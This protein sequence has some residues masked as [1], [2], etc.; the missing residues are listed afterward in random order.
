MRVL[1]DNKPSA[2]IQ[3]D[4]GIV[5]GLALSPLLFELSISALLRLLDSTGILHQRARGPRV[6]PSCIRGRSLPVCQ[7]NGRH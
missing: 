3:L 5:Q 4:T 6:E 1:V 2:A 7:L